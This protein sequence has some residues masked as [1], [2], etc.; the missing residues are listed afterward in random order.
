[1][2]L[3][4]TATSPPTVWFMPPQLVR[5]SPST[6]HD[7]G[8][9]PAPSTY[10][11]LIAPS[12]LSCTFKVVCIDFKP[13]HDALSCQLPNHHQHHTHTGYSILYTSLTATVVDSGQVI[14]HMDGSHPDD[15]PISLLSRKFQ[16]AVFIQLEHGGPVRVARGLPS[17]T[18]VEGSARR[19]QIRWSP[20]MLI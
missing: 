11:Q 7:S 2:R 6:V 19:D 12:R 5:S 10:Q 14:L 4:S 20:I 18:H 13:R 15:R 9:L 3:C 8:Q 17:F 16:L 1:M